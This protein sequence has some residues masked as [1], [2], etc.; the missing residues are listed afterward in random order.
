MPTH[1]G[2]PYQLGESSKS[3][4]APIDPKQISAMFVEI[5]AKLDILKT[6]KRDWPK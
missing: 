4:I 3:H 1:I 5:N 6:F 2:H